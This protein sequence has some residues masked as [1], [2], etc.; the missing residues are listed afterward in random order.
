MAEACSSEIARS[1][2][3]T[4]YRHQHST[5]GAGCDC[6][7][8]LRGVWREMHGAEPETPPNYTAS[9][10]E[11]GRTELMLDAADRWLVRVDAP[12][13]DTVLIFRMR[14]GMIAKHCGIVTGDD[15]LVHAC[16]FA[17]AVVEVPLTQEWCRKIAGVYRFG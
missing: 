4:P 6:L 17:R 8:L 11:A 3:G 12:A 2:I 14:H 7:G 13:P 9:W 1:W 10:G 5:K 16:S 15:T